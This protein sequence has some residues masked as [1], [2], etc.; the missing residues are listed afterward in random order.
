MQ[1]ESQI[2][3]DRRPDVIDLSG[4]AYD[5]VAT[6]PARRTLIICSA[7]RTGSYELCRLLLAAGIG[8]PHEYVH[9]RIAPEFGRRFGLGANPL[10]RS[11]IGAYIEALRL[12]RAQGGVFAVNLQHWQFRESLVNESGRALFEGA[13][14]V[15]LF[16]S[17][18]GNQVTSY[19]VAMNT[20]TWDFSGRRTSIP[21]A[22]PRDLEGRVAQF[23]ADLNRIATEDTGFRELF[24]R[25]GIGPQFVTMD[26]LFRAPAQIVRQ[27]AD[28][29]GTGVDEGGLGAMISRSAPYPRDEA[30]RLRATNGL[31]DVL[32]RRAFGQ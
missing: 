6:E 32:K 24:G 12:R 4:P 18:I 11:S 5:V 29:L 25:A 28:A 27:I 17:D 23:E 8:I 30:A 15:H 1:Q 10:A 22:Y 26:D 13:H 21:R 3:L 7:P 14:V 20:G 16:R 31:A 9:P 2:P 19:R